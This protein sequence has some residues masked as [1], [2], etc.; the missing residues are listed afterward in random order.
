MWQWGGGGLSCTSDSNKGMAEINIEPV[1]KINIGP[2]LVDVQLA[3]DIFHLHEGSNRGE[4][5]GKK[6]ATL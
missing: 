4:G 5:A 6:G 1:G 2:L 3:L